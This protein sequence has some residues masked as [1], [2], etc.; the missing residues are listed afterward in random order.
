MT[1]NWIT[2]TDADVLEPTSQERKSIVTVK[3][4]DDLGDICEAVTNQ[5]RQAYLLGSRDV[6][7][8]GTIPEGLKAHAIAIAIWRFVSEGV[9]KNEGIQTK[10]R[11]SAYR[12][13]LDFLTS[14][15]KADVGKATDPS[16][17]E[18]RRRF[19]DCQEEG[20]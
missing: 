18:R 17:S 4:R 10:Q 7:D 16:I 19:K 15:A 3:G 1:E 5:V 13:A 8:A 14:I 12:N 20:A 9:P 11:E 6:G 2:F